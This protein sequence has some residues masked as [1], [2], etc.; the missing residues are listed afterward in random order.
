MTIKKSYSVETTLTAHKVCQLIND[1]KI[2]DL[3]LVYPKDKSHN[4]TFSSS[5]V[6]QRNSVATS[7]LRAEPIDD[8]HVLVGYN[9]A[10]IAYLVVFTLGESTVTVGTPVQFNATSYYVQGIVK[11]N[12]NRFVLIFASGTAL[13]GY[14]ISLSD[15]YEISLA[16]G[17]VTTIYNTYNW[18]SYSGGKLEDGKFISFC[19]NSSSYLCIVTIYTVTDKT[20]SVK[21]NTQ[22]ASSNYPILSATGV[23]SKT[24]VV[25]GFESSVGSYYY[26]NTIGVIVDGYS[27]RVSNLSLSSTNVGVAYLAVNSFFPTSDFGG[28]FFFKSRDTNY[29]YAFYLT[30]DDDGITYLGE[31]FTSTLNIANGFD[32]KKIDSTHALIAGANAGYTFGVIATI[33]RSAVTLATLSQI[34]AVV[35]N[36][37]TLALCSDLK[38]L[39]VHIPTSNN[40]LWGEMITLSLSSEADTKEGSVLGVA[41][42]NAG[43]VVLKGT[44]KGHSNLVTGNNYY[45]DAYGNLTSETFGNTYVGFAIS[46][47][48][49][50]IP[51]FIV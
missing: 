20:I 25:F 46:D 34:H 40:Y 48:E 10:T 19:G 33:S 11:N 29:L 30:V 45:Y 23:L 43:N 3:P 41:E 28:Y 51:D 37:P 2:N 8:T 27:V 42:D 31:L 12:K 4:T 1:G 47:T 26:F 50:Y 39:S 44:S 49:L 14:V 6:T 18:G 21:T 13:Y 16:G 36:S 5:D 32:V 22:V 17:A 38:C 9:L 15:L 35:A 7:Y 24:K